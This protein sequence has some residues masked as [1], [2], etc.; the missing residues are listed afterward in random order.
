[1]SGVAIPGQGSGTA[2]DTGCESVTGISAAG[3]AKELDEHRAI[4]I[5]AQRILYSICI[6]PMAIGG[7]LNTVAKTRSNVMR[8]DT[9]VPIPLDPH[10]SKE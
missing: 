9:A 10:A 8:K 4:N 3:G 5:R 2:S 1:M 7:E 6:H